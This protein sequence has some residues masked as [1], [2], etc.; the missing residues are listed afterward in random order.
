[1]AEHVHSQSSHLKTTRRRA[2][3]LAR[4]PAISLHLTARILGTQDLCLCC[5]IMLAV[6]A[7]IACADVGDS[8]VAGPPLDA[9]RCDRALHAIQTSDHWGSP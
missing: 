1:V 4:G 9:A 6:P 7:A 5:N 3:S 8:D 2:L